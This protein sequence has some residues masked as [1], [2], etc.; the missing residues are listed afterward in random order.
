[1]AEQP[2]ACADI[3]YL[4][5][6]GDGYTTD[7]TE[8]GVVFEW[9]GGA[10][11]EMHTACCWDESQLGCIACRYGVS[12][13]AFCETA[14][15]IGHPEV[16]LSGEDCCVGSPDEACSRILFPRVVGM[17]T[18]TDYSELGTTH[19]WTSGECFTMTTMCCRD[20]SR[21]ECV[22][23]INTMAPGDLCEERGSEFPSVCI[24]VE[25][26]RPFNPALCCAESPPDECS[27][28]DVLT[29]IGDGFVTDFRQVGVT[30]EWTHG[31]CFESHFQ[32]CQ[33]QN[34]RECMACINSVLPE[35]LCDAHSETFPQFCLAGSDCCMESPPRSCSSLH[36]P[37]AIGMGF[38][39][40]YTQTGK[41]YTW[42][43]GACIESDT[44]CCQ[45]TDLIECV[46]CMNNVLP[47]D[48][49]DVHSNH[50]LCAPPPPVDVCGHANGFPS[51]AVIRNSHSDRRL[52]ARDGVSGEMGVGAD[53]GGNIAEDQWWNL[54]DAG[55][56]SYFVTNSH[57]D[58]RLFAQAS[59]TGEVGVGALA[60]GERWADQ[61]WF[62]EEDSDC[63]YIFRNV[64]S[65]RRLFSQRDRSGDDGVGAMAT[66][67]LW[68]DQ[69]WFIDEA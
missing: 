45:S 32:C 37:R 2:E 69:K 44:L 65:G 5:A 16:C 21:L 7:H 14:D 3:N 51:P 56:G 24:Q 4:R 42:S 22:A 43:N 53:A 1:M 15:A 40:D 63:T 11:F 59:G 25:P 68:A 54:E 57:S 20:M 55:D 49:C 46:A 58:R 30:Y 35:N 17:A 9:N 39:T 12:P 52:Y 31:A 8:V 61:R 10:C 47:G 28:V 33:D 38:T 19:A 29:A 23:C 26:P 64:H 67:Q 27:G 48:F 60:T 62:I 36:F 41:T 6:I 66:G 34:R 18:T 13:E 50:Q